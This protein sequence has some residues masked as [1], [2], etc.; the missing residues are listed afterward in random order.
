M[1]VFDTYIT[2][3]QARPNNLNVLSSQAKLFLN[4]DI[5]NFETGFLSY[6]NLGETK[7]SD[8]YQYILPYYNFDTVLDKNYFNGSIGIE[9]SGSN[10]LSN[11]NDLK[12]NIIN[13]E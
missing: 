5:Y 2:K 8:R 4:H 13:F 11:T 3:S 12:S 10:N 7:E 1:K 6:E 9:S